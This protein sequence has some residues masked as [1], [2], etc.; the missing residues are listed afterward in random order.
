MTATRSPGWMPLARRAPGD[1]RRHAVE[2]RVGDPLAAHPQRVLL[3][4][5]RGGRR[6]VGG[7]VGHRCVLSS[8]VG[9][10]CPSSPRMPSACQASWTR[11]L[12][13]RSR[14]RRSGAGLGSRTARPAAASSRPVDDGGRVSVV[15]CM[16]DSWRGCRD[17]ADARGAAGVPGGRLRCSRRVGV[18]AVPGVRR[19]AGRADVAGRRLAASAAAA[20]VA[21]TVEAVT[22]GEVAAAGANAHGWVRDHAPSLRQGGA[23]DVAR[24]ALAVAP[25]GSIVAAGGRGAGPRVA[26]RGGGGGGARGRVSPGLAT[27]CWVRWSGWSRTWSARRGRR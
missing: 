7:E 6:E 10:G 24:V 14:G 8:G 25:T 23:G 26:G 15:V 3:R 19:R 5:V 20:R 18:G 13:R 1:S 22:R 17:D 9:G 2:L 11:P 4:V 16:F 21:V 12:A 27:R